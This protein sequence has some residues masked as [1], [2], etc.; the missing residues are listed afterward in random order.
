MVILYEYQNLN[1]EVVK[2]LRETLLMQSS[3]L[4]GDGAVSNLIFPPI[5]LLA[6]V[7]QFEPLDLV[8]NMDNEDDAIRA[9]QSLTEAAF[10]MGHW[11]TYWSHRVAIEAT[12]RNIRA[13][14]AS[15]QWS[16]GHAPLAKRLLQEYNIILDRS[17][18][19]GD[20]IR[21]GAQHIN[22]LTS[23]EETRRGIQQSDSVR[24]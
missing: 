18:S 10:S 2:N 8:T 7:I 23:I 22:T 12:V 14:L 1:M 21:E 11:E 15:E 24:R 13:A 3:C 19:Q 6:L 9:A 5:D 4:H 20:Y 17:R 16:K